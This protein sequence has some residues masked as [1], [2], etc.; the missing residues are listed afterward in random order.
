MKLLTLFL[1]LFILSCSKD[2]TSTKVTEQETISF[3]IPTSIKEY[4]NDVVFYK[5]PDALKDELAAHTIA[6][7]TNILSYGER[8]NYLYDADE[9]SNNPENVVLIYSSES[10]NKNEYTSP[11]NPHQP[12][13]FN[14][15]HVYP[16][17]LI[18]NTAIGDLHHLRT[19]D[20]SV[21]SQRSNYPFTDGSGNYALVDGNKWFP[22]DEWKGDVARMIMYLNLRYNESFSDVGS[23]SLF[24][25][26]N[27]E[28]P[29]SE[30]EIQRNTIIYSAQGNRNPFIDN[31][32]LATI[33]WGGQEAENKWQ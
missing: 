31:P 12:Q 29:V 27:A 7:H 22:G 18:G 5:N 28:D 6:M 19:C 10:R 24:L 9:D 2:T 21:N 20:A 33:L 8:H 14:T 32:Y 4:Y 17:S 13:T 15:E 11:N 16:R 25:K 1:S 30:I 3:N 26:W 23:L